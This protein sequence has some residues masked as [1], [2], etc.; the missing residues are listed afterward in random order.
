MAQPKAKSIHS[1]SNWRK[2]AMGNLVS[3]GIIIPEKKPEDGKYEASEFNAKMQ[4]NNATGRIEII[5]SSKDNAL[6]LPISAAE[7][8]LTERPEDGKGFGTARVSKDGNNKHLFLRG[9]KDGTVYKANLYL[10]EP[11]RLVVSLYDEA[12][13][14]A[15]YE[16][17]SGDSSDV[18]TV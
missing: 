17:Q 2:T 16:S 3:N 14:R 4:K 8:T 7:I 5:M 15:S 11:T 18:K 12:E 10:T 13:D 1:F 6:G 9:T